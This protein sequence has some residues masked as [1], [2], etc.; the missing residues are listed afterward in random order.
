MS[1][2]LEGLCGD[3][4]LA[5]VY[6]AVEECYP[7]VERMRHRANPPSAAFAAASAQSPA[8]GRQKAATAATDEK[9]ER[10]LKVAE[11]LFHEQGYADTTL[12]QIVRELGVTKPF[13][14]Y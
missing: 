6:R 4:W 7:M 14:Y 2:P 1:S 3:R 13:V 11:R 10:I 9:R 12:E 8:R 5:N